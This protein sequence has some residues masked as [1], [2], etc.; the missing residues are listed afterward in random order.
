MTIRLTWTATN[1]QTARTMKENLSDMLRGAKVTAMRPA[2]WDVSWLTFQ[3]AS[4]VR[5]NP[6]SAVY[7]C[8]LW[9][10]PSTE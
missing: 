1:P 2:G 6:A 10:H 7:G 9:V 4:E 5:Q 3:G 8:A